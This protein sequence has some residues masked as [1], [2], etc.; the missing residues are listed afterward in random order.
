M[1]TQRY[2]STSFWDD[3]W[4]RSL[5]PSERYLYMYLLTNPQTNIAGIYQITMDRIGFDTG[6]DERTLKP[7]IDRFQKA[8]KAYFV[9]DEWIILP[10]WPKHQKADSK[11]TIRA[12]IESSLKSTPKE[13]LEYAKSVWYLYDIDTILVSYQYQPSYPDPDPD[14]EFDSDSHSDVARASEPPISKIP[15]GYPKLIFDAWSVLPGIPKPPEYLTW[16]LGPSYRDVMDAIQGYHSDEVL[17]AISN[18]EKILADP[19]R[20]W[21]KA[22]P[23]IHA[24]FRGGVFQ[25][26]RPSVF[27]GAALAD[28]KSDGGETTDEQ[29]ERLRREGKFDE[30]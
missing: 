5:D 23:S 28:G 10:T 1:A 25:A 7:M 9:F 24:F 3:K 2:I 19:S 30:A 26:C 14:P 22:R 12:G 20:Y 11:S 6:Y 17:G 4:I 15:N 16:I 21:I 8:G 27:P 18:F 13:V 29:F